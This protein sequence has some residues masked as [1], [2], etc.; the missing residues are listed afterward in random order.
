[1]KNL[2][3]SYKIS[4]TT[5]LLGILLTACPK[6]E[7][8]RIDQETKDYC[9]FTEGSYWIY[10]DIATLT[11][12]SVIINNPVIYDPVIANDHSESDAYI[13]YSLL[14]SQDTSYNVRTKLAT[15]YKCNNSYRH[16]CYFDFD[17]IYH[18]GKINKTCQY[19][20]NT[21]LIDE[22]DNYSIDG[23]FYPNVKIF[24]L[25][26]HGTEK[27]ILLGKTYWYY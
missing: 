19:Y 12:D 7:N 5:L 2:R 4:I 9:L 1:M 8:V 16:A 24:K 13:T 20:W 23:I 22:K 17:I 15:G 27:N 25:F 26:E 18:K 6:A 10:Q 21:I 14:H 11:I 3:F